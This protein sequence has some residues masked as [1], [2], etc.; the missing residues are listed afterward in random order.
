MKHR[1][2]C[3]ACRGEYSDVQTDG[4]IYAHACGP[5]PADSKNPERERPDKRD[6]NIVVNRQRVVIGILSEGAGVTCLTDK[7]IKEP[8][9]ISTLYKNIEAEEAKRNA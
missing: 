4:A 5:L 3:N 6:E 2:R 9:W 7:Q 8:R 1:F